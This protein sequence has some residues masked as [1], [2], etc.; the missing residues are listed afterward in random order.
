M[1]AIT[2]NDDV[3]HYEV[4]GRGRA[5]VLLHGWLGSWR[6]W[7]PALQQ[8]QARYRVYAVDLFGFGDS[9]KKP[10]RYT[11]DKQ[12]ELLADFMRE[13]GIPKAAVIGHGLG[14]VVAAEYARRA[15]DTVARMMLISLPLFDPGG[16]D[17]RV[18]VVPKPA[19]LPDL[20]GF[21][22][23]KPVIK[24]LAGRSAQSAAL[25]AALA[26]AARIRADGESARVSLAPV[27][28]DVAETPGYNPLP[29]LLPDLDSILS[30]AFKR[31]EPEYAKLRVDLE[32]TDARALPRSISAFDAGHMLDTLRLLIQPTVVLHGIDDPVLPL[33]NE[34][35]WNYVTTGRD[36]TLLPVLLPGIRHFPMLEYGRFARL[37]S[38]FLDAPDINRLEIKDRWR[39]R[40]R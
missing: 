28:E 16:L 10:E 5:V 38:D 22:S 33:P 37:A 1:S 3:I 40:T 14:A 20:T 29:G 19:P 2:V 25:N 21:A 23:P 32:R 30:K 4:L 18:P 17:Q 39:R 35:V 34:A 15:P 26:E 9:G 11:L 13:L 6:Y 7:I 24:P 27:A 31:S 8:L 12:I 36:A